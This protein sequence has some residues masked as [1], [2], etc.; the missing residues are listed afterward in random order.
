MR[1]EV[2]IIEGIRNEMWLDF[3]MM[4]SRFIY[5]NLS[6]CN[7]REWKYDGSCSLPWMNFNFRSRHRHISAGSLSL[8]HKHVPTLHHFRYVLQVR[9]LLSM[10][11]CYLS[12]LTFILLPVCRPPSLSLRSTQCSLAQILCLSL[13]DSLSDLYPPEHV[14]EAD[15][16]QPARQLCVVGLV[17]PQRRFGKPAIYLF[18]GIKGCTLSRDLWPLSRQKGPIS[19]IALS[20]HTRTQT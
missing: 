15:W 18:R 17:P 5:L 1:N 8:T 7:R 19:E 9:L 11:L 12:F 3:Y 20:K 4:K 2:T 13:S 14:L 10:L 16:L 6:V